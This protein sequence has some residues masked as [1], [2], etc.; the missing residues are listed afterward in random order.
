MAALS[1]RART[2]C[3]LTYRY[4]RRL[5]GNIWDGEDLLQDALMRVFSLLG[6]IDADLN[7]RAYLIRT[8]TNCGS[9][10]SGASARN[11]MRCVITA[12]DV[13]TDATAT[14]A[15]RKNADGIAAAGKEARRCC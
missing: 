3:D 5:T 8:A 13:A 11:A 2:A 1:R 10:A 15:G 6:K 14:F 12:H 7:P 4:C 9:T